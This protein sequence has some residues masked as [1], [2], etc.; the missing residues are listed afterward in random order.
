MIIDLGT[1]V[2]VRVRGSRFGG[3]INIEDVHSSGDRPF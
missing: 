2:G 3:G 1:A